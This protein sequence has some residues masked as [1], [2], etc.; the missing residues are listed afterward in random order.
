M[1]LYKLLSSNNDGLLISLFFS[2]FFPSYHFIYIP[3]KGLFGS[4]QILSNSVRRKQSSYCA[5]TSTSH[6]FL[7]LDAVFFIKALRDSW[8]PGRN[9]CALFFHKF[10][11]TRKNN[12]AFFVLL[13]L[14]TCFFCSLKL[15]FW[16]GLELQLCQTGNFNPSIPEYFREMHKAAYV[17]HNVWSHQ[18]FYFFF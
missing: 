1:V 3:L 2:K 16:Q 17:V 18:W 9:S 15:G 10:Q 14:V 8:R 7:S 12:S 5:W 6:V 11:Q 13:D 4:G